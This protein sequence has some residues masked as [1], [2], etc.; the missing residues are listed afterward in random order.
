MELGPVLCFLPDANARFMH[1][2]SNPLVDFKSYCCACILKSSVKPNSY[3]TNIMAQLPPSHKRIDLR[4]LLSQAVWLV[5]GFGGKPHFQG[6]Y[7]FCLSWVIVLLPFC[8]LYPPQSLP[9]LSPS[10]WSKVLWASYS[11]CDLINLL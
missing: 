3:D 5:Q 2:C 9:F 8:F 10:I 7:A 11:A 1:P 4:A 6:Y